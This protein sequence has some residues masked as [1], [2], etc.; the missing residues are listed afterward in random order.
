M[1]SHPNAERTGRI[2]VDVF[3][4]RPRK[5]DLP[6]RVLLWPPFP[7]PQVLYDQL[8][9]ECDEKRAAERGA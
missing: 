2:K 4:M 1:D 3:T 7:A 9:G 5:R 8:L 6:G